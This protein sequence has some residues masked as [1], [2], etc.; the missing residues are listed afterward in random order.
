MS[1][2]ELQEQ[3]GLSQPSVF[4]ILA[5]LGSRILRIGARRSARY[6]LRRNLGPLVG[7]QWPIYRIDRMG[8]ATL[9]AQLT[10]LHGG[11]LVVWSG[12][13]PRWLESTY[14]D[15]LFSGLPFFLEELRPQGF[16]GRL[17]AQALTKSGGYSP[18]PR[19]WSQDDVLTFL[20]N[21]GDDLPGDLVVGERML[22]RIQR[23]QLEDSRAAVTHAD[24]AG[25]YPDLA[26]SVTR[27]DAPGS[28]AGGEQPKFLAS[29]MTADGV[30][31]VLVKFSAPTS[32][33]IGQRWAD[34][35]LSEWHALELLRAENISASK[36]EIF[37]ARGRRFL[38][39]KRF[40]RVQSFGRHGVLSLSGVE[41]SMMDPS[42]SSWISASYGLEAA[43]LLNPET[44]A[45]L[46]RLACFGELIANNDMHLGNVGFW[47]GDHAPLDLAPVY[48]MLPMLLA[49]TIQGE[50]V[51]RDFTPRPPPPELLPDWTRA[52][53]WALEFWRRIRADDRFSP[54]F[55]AYAA[56]WHDVVMRLR[57]RFAPS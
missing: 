26:E 45:Q 18:D 36:A 35:L 7:S 46:R 51:H 52:C 50:L 30:N 40:D 31:P 13:D 22:E 6:A 32:T 55:T 3:L 19:Q 56:R 24:R 48:D 53:R 57:D 1:A 16:L 54:E 28:S 2:R 43:Q 17:T 12:A 15:G 38:E 42:A 33:P 20:L 5:A 39:V 29:V 10:A 49:P 47:F 37:D 34:L 14:P 27:G 23:R 41:A 44:A 8:K 25:R 4:R 11:F 9:W 21:E